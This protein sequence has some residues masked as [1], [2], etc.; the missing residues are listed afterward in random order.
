M[1]KVPSYCPMRHENGNCLPHGGFC[2]AVNSEVCK[3]MRHAY[4]MGV[5]GTIS[6]LVSMMAK[7]CWKK[8][9]RG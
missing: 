2:T 7:T 9:E 8:A 4:N 3:A 5:D 6:D 1:N